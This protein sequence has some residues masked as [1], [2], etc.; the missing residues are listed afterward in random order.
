MLDL[1][2]PA[3]CP[4]CHEIIP[5]RCEL[6]CKECVS[7]LPLNCGYQCIKCGKPVEEP[8]ELCHDCMEYTHEFEQG[9]GIFCYD[10]IMRRSIHKFKYQGR[11]EYGRFYGIAAWRYGKEQLKKWKPEV[12]VPVPIHTSRKRERGYNQAEIIAEVLG[13]C[14]DLPVAADVVIRKK[15]TIAQKELSSEERRK[16]LESAFAKGKNPLRWRR[17]LLIDDIYTT[18][19]TA[20][21]VSRILRE[22][23]AEEIY[24][25]S[26]CIGRDFVV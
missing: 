25:L 12:L 18:G 23:G 24:V 13:G 4:V 22:C 6:I 19:S 3:R 20:D 1:I 10:E 14:M 8:E 17:V 7:L 21:A 9:M 26:I 2:Y 16:N 11:R 5:W 15:K